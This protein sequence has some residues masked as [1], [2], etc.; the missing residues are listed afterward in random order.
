MP[1]QGLQHEVQ[2]SVSKDQQPATRN[3]VL[4]ESSS[5]SWTQCSKPRQALRQQRYSSWQGR[6][7]DR[8]TIKACFRCTRNILCTYSSKHTLSFLCSERRNRSGETPVR[9]L[10]RTG[11]QEN[12]GRARARLHCNLRPELHCP[13]GTA[14]R[15]EWLHQGGRTPGWSRHPLIRGPLPMVWLW[16][17]RSQRHRSTS[18]H[19]VS[20]AYL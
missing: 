10:R 17:Q 4:T 12:I 7:R 5:S 18:L 8:Y 11:R 9:S 19:P 1:W 2:N 13:P 3:T 20:A 16:K 6:S 14:L 15:P